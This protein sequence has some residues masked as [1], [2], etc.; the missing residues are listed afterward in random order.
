[1]KLR[2]TKPTKQTKLGRK[3]SKKKTLRRGN[4]KERQTLRD[5]VNQFV[6][7]PAKQLAPKATSNKPGFRVT[8]AMLI[9]AKMDRP[10]S[11]K[12]AHEVFAFAKP[13]PGVVPNGEHVA[14]DEAIETAIG[15]AAN[16]IY[17]GA[18]SQGVTFMGYPYLAELTQRAEYRR[19]SEI[20]ATEMTR[21]WIEIK[22]KGDQA[23]EQLEAAKAKLSENGDEDGEQAEPEEKPSPLATDF[24]PDTDDEKVEAVEG[25]KQDELPPDEG[26]EPDDGEELQGEDP[27]AAVQKLAAKQAKDKRVLELEK[28]FE[29][30]NVKECFKKMVELDGFFG[31][32]H[33]FVDTGYV[34][35]PIELKTPIGD[36]QNKISMYKLGKGTIKRLQ[37]VEPVWTYPTAYNAIDPLKPTW[38]TPE[39]W[40]VMGK[41][42]HATRLLTF[43]GREVPD[44]LK[45]A[46]AFGGLSLSQLAKECVDNWLRTRGSVSDLIEA[47]SI[48]I[49]STNMGSTMQEGEGNV[50]NRAEFFNVT[51]NN[52]GL[53]VIDKESEDFK[54]VAAPIGG[55]SDLQAQSQEHICSVTGIPLVKYTGIS[56]TGLNATSEFEMQAFYEWIKAFQESFLRP[57]LTRIFHMIQINLWGKVDEDLSFEF[58]PLYSLNE[59]EEAER[60][61]T[62][63]DRDKV[64]VDAGVLDPTEVRQRLAEDSDGPYAGIDPDAA[65]EPPEPEMPP[66]MGGGGE[67]DDMGGG[68]D[69]GP[70]QE[71]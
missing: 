42:V 54:N 70:P 58:K 36:G 69:N 8:E 71:V 19:I 34:D 5:Q 21:E 30:L 11:M 39:T 22:A 14:M 27:E 45:P 25:S 20:I 55:L 2:R 68:G 47:F 50:R 32:A 46:Y 16:S 60:Q 59:K 67:G 26:A 31:R 41:E 40:F 48:M 23:Q 37:P 43:I 56:P 64:Y 65:P 29:R 24:D 52:R 4:A 38:Y 12:L 28:E 15:W 10:K 66:G 13:M 6:D 63:A 62:E 53:V 51:R 61:K 3:P 49:L 7:A 9:A 1:V 17:N 33:L 18:F 44:L 35:N 57:N